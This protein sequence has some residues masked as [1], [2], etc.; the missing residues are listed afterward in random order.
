MSETAIS[1]VYLLGAG[2]SGTTLLA[3]VM[4]RFP[5]VQTLG[6]M[7]Q[8]LEHIKF[9]KP[10]SCGAALED[11]SFWSPI[12]RKLDVDE[13]YI[14]QALL[15][16]GRYEAHGQL[17]K[18]V[19]LKD[20][21]SE[22]NAVQELIFG[23]IRT[24]VA[25]EYL[26]DSSKY[27]ARYLRFR[28]NNRFKV[29][30]IYMVRDVRGVIHSFSKQVQTPKG[31]LATILYYSIINFFGQLVC[32]T[33]PCILKLRYEDLVEDTAGSLRRIATH[34]S[35]E[36]TGEIT[37]AGYYDIPHIIG[38]NRLKANKTLEIKKDDAWKRNMPRGRQMI[39]YLLAAPF[40]LVNRYRF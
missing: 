16:S 5:E 9:N 4:N 1:L 40:M 34:L 14:D 26:L 7:H 8:F 20:I 21:R 22:Y 23:A 3:T 10:C 25:K 19:V 17:P 30:G 32:W 27:I 28:R 36:E 38:G 2:R 12:L 29:K 6:E 33:D 18:L 15:I 31:P 35:G 11:C 39:Y 13:K 24:Q 37:D